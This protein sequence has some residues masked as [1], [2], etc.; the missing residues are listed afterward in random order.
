M[1]LAPTL[2]LNAG[3]GAAIARPTFSRDFAGEKTLNNGTGPA[4]T[5]TRASNA[6]FFDASGTLCLA[7]HNL[8]L[9]SEGFE[10][11]VWSKE[12]GAT[13]SSNTTISPNGSQTAD[14][15]T[16]TTT[17]ANRVE[18]QFGSA[19][20]NETLTFSVWLKGSGTI[21]ILADTSTGVGGASEVSITLTSSWTR[22]SATVTYSS[23]TGN[24]RVAVIWRPQST[25]TSVDVWGAQ[26]VFGSIAGEY[27][28][29]TDAAASMPRFD[30]D[31]ATG[32][33]RGLLIEE[34]RT[35][36]I[37]NSQAG[38]A[39]APSTAPT[40]WF[41]GG[42]LNGIAREI[43]GTGTENGL[44][45]VDI[46]WSGTA[47]GAFDNNTNFD[48]GNQASAAS[49]QTWT[50]S[51]YVKVAAGSTSG[52]SG[53]N[54]VCEENNGSFLASTST[55]LLSAGATLSRFAA[56]RTLNN[57]L[58]THAH[59][60]IRATAASGTTL[61]LT[62]RIAAPQLEQGAFPTSYIPTTTAAATRSADS[63]VV[64][65]I[66]SF[67]NQAE[68]TLFAEVREN[69]VTTLYG[70]A[71]L[72]TNTSD[73]RI[74]VRRSDSSNVS[75]FVTIGG[76]NQASLFRSLA[77]AAQS[78]RLIAAYATNDTVAV[79]NGGTATTDTSAT[80]P[81]L[82]HFRIGAL[83]AVSPATGPSFFLNGHIRRI[84]YWSRRLSNS[85]LQQLT[86]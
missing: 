33:S 44:N 47:T 23:P 18:Q 36:S 3:S 35:N 22:H 46:R 25:A 13:V 24:R 34:A 4:I 76:A 81:T 32:A 68:G 65:P 52:F 10:N 80:L 40:N 7:P 38:G 15:I 8:L 67:Y 77:N 50:S 30:H 45:Y 72:D 79:L 61:D 2:L 20:N 26:V 69:G 62:L 49:G 29:T 75:S 55:S 59:T 14:T 70:A 82:T 63:A 60:Y 71:S 17:N 66:S 74:D 16:F 41:F 27:F 83:A 73:N 39:S 28:A 51:V 64:T 43:I 1:L 84:A 57:A 12:S 56:S 54:I 37:R 78:Y 6:T 53:I 19:V 85:L 9:H 58:T 31:P 5:F 11:A 42:T 86:T 48:L 21:R